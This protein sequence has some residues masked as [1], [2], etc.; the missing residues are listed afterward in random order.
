MIPTGPIEDVT[1]VVTAHQPTDGLAHLAAET[2]PWLAGHYAALVAYCSRDTHPAILHLLAEHGATVRRDPRES[3]GILGI[4]EVRRATLRAGLEAGTAHLQMCD[5]DRALHWAAHYPDEMENTIAGVAG[6]D[7]LVLGRTARAWA[8]H[9]AYQRDT[10][11]LFNHAFALATGLAWDIGAG[12]RGLSRRA[13]EALLAL[14]REQ[15]VGVDAEWPL[16]LLN[17]NRQAEANGLPPFGSATDHAK[18]SSSKQPT[19]LAPRSRPP[20]ATRRG[21]PVSRPARPAGPSAC[22][23]PISSPRPSPTMP[24]QSPNVNRE[25]QITNRSALTDRRTSDI[26]NRACQTKA[27]EDSSFRQTMARAGWKKRQRVLFSQ[28]EYAER[29]LERG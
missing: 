16:L 14:S 15:T 13:A 11:P 9:P 7:L 29:H 24:H 6:H 25:S 8:T 23:W 10:E 3:Q 28:Q 2:L 20:A 12:S 27:S 5:F 22:M 21:W 1:L 19:G 17:H 26:L 4:G 18:G